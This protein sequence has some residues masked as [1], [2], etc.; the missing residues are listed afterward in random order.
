M[1]SWGRI[2]NFL[3]LYSRANHRLCKKCCPIAEFEISG[4]LLLDWVEQEEH[5]LLYGMCRCKIDLGT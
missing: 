4:G 1:S 2:E 5:L 3:L